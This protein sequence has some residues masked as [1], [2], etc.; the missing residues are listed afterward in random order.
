MYVCE[1]D[2]EDTDL[3]RFRD[4]NDARMLTDV[5]LSDVN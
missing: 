1:G 5:T 4:I 2:K 3:T